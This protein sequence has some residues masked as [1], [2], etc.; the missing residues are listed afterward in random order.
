MTP[1][2]L[3]TG[4]HRGIG[5]GISEALHKSGFQIAMASLE[6]AANAEV[7]A[8]LEQLGEG[9][10]YYQ[11]DV[12]EIAQHNHLLERIESDLG[13]INTFVSNAGVPAKERG[14]LLDLAPQS[15]DHVMD[16]NLRGAFFLAQKV[17]QRML[18]AVDDLYKSITFV[19][20]VSAEMVSVERG[21]YCISKAGGSM[22]ARLF[23]VRLAA[24]GIGVFELRPGIIETPMTAGVKD[25]YSDRIAGGLVPAK[26]WGQ[27]Q[28][29]GALMPPIAT[30]QM[31]FATG[32]VIAVDGGLS[33]HRL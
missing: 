15:F 18:S 10:H 11:H 19:T 26:R 21:E 2:A 29:I 28:D 3:I 13:P 27:P 4:A 14:D 12:T 31:A 1:V 32:S 6:P 9:A 33:L 7:Q 23:A 16:V 22:M 5:L 30:G 20:S 25:R 24:H 8:A 17:A